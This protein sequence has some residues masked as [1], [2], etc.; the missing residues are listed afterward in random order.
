[1]RSGEQRKTF[2]SL[3]PTDVGERVGVR[4]QR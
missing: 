4:G 1:V 2:G 3:S